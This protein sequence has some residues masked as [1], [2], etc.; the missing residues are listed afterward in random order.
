MLKESLGERL[1]KERELKNLDIKTISK[2][3]NI[4][5]RYI[6]ALENNDFDKFPSET[7]LFGFLRNYGEYLNIDDEELVHLY[8][9]QQISE[10]QT[11]LE[12]LTRSTKRTPWQFQWDQN[13]TILIGKIILVIAGLAILF[14][15]GS[16]LFSMLQNQS[17][18]TMD[19]ANQNQKNKIPGFKSVEQIQL[20]RRKA[21]TL[22]QKNQAAIFH[23]ENREYAFLLL[24]NNPNEKRSR[25][26]IFPGKQELWLPLRQEIA[27]QI[28]SC[29]YEITFILKAQTT[30]T[31]KIEVR[32]NKLINKNHISQKTKTTG[33]DPKDLAI[34]MKISLNDNSYVET[35]TDGKKVFAGLLHNGKEMFWNAKQMIQIHLG[36]ADGVVITVNNK[37]Y[38]FRGKVVNKTFVW[39]KDPLDP[40]KFQIHVRDNL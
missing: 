8:R 25:I 14:Q 20:I 13:K 37:E 22:L 36:N 17:M 11:P 7:Y 9:A 21:E 29:N 5:P 35:Y 34:R 24:E 40:S 31:A 38:K 4:I 18:Q 27:T 10:S 23:I 1:K 12:E 6:Q 15:I 30:N 33:L 28:P 26:R 39:K 19:T 32:Q 16:M 2:E 3:T